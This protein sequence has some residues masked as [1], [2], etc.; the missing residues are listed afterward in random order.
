MRSR[1]SA[2]KLGLAD[3]L[4]QTTHPDHQHP[5][6]TK[7]WREEILTFSQNTDFIG[8]KILDATNELDHSTVTFHAILESSLEDISFKEKSLF[9]KIK[10]R[11]LYV[12]PIDLRG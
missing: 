7:K 2:Y 6:N 9:K 3:Y 11:W 8:L 5:T 4:I 10:G 12:A 1:Y